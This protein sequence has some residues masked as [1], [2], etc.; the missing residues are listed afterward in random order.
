MFVGELNEVVR[1]NNGCK[2]DSANFMPVEV[3]G[4]SL[5]RFDGGVRV[6]HLGMGE[7]L[8]GRQYSGVVLNPNE[9][10]IVCKNV[11]DVWN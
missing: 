6:V 2:T 1:G 5:R 3:R 9:K 7:I 10:L 4:I 8:T 11:L